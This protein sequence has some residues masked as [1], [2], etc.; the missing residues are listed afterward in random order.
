MIGFMLGFAT[1]TMAGHLSRD[2]ELRYS[3]SGV[4]S[5]NFCV[6]V[7]RANGLE[8]STTFVECKKTGDSA[9]DI[10]AEYKQGDAVHIEGSLRQ[11][12]WKPDGP[13]HLIVD[14][15]LVERV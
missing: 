13:S 8:K 11:V 12:R 3:T 10:A 1:V 4:P 2:P 14:A 15:A 7:S 9:E 5:V 6:K